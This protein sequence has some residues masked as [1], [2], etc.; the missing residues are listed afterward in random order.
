[1]TTSSSMTRE[2]NWSK[3]RTHTKISPSC[4]LMCKCVLTFHYKIQ[5]VTALFHCLAINCII[6][7]YLT[8]LIL[9]MAPVSDM[10]VESTS[11]PSPK[12]QKIADLPSP[13]TLQIAKLSEN[14]T[15]P[16]RGSPR[17]AGYDLYSAE[18]GDTCPPLDFQSSPSG[19]Q[20]PCS[21][22]G[23]GQD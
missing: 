12:K 1:M 18:V 3:S 20:D 17:A 7:D 5:S 19:R 16:T 2:M 22:E 15:V 14:A 11:Q 13:I 23:P 4:V 9:T 8:D 21:W 10:K 6:A